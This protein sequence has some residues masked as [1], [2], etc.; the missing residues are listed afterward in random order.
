MKKSK[1]YITNEEKIMF[2]RSTLDNLNEKLKSAF[3]LK[4]STREVEV[5]SLSINS[6]SL[7]RSTDDEITYWAGDE[8]AEKFSNFYTQRQEAVIDNLI[9]ILSSQ[10]NSTKVF[11]SLLNEAAEVGCRFDVSIQCIDKTPNGLP[12]LPLEYSGLPQLNAGPEYDLFKSKV[13]CY[14]DPNT[15]T[16]ETLTQCINTAETELVPRKKSR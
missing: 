8:E 9:P 16:K 12:V 1:L 2:L 15:T 7:S 14:G 13:K 5:I 3:H 10:N 11:M 6:T 4:P